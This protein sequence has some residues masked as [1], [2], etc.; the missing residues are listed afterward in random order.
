M[1]VS[2]LVEELSSGFWAQ[3]ARCK[4]GSRQLKLSLRFSAFGSIPPTTPNVIDIHNTLF[5]HID[6]KKPNAAITLPMMVTRRQPYL[7][8]KLETRGPKI[9][10]ISSVYIYVAN[11]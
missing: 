2:A 1:H 3:L 11:C 6:N 8:A 4:N 9:E 10:S 7:F 5:A